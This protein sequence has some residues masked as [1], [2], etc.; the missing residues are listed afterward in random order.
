MKGPKDKKMSSTPSDMDDPGDGGATAVVMGLLLVVVVVLGAFYYFGV[1]GA[2]S[3]P[4]D[5]DV[6]PGQVSV[7]PTRH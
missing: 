7:A 3:R 1:I 6:H 4:I 5:I 2:Q